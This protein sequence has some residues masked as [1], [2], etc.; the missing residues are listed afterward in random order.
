M[1]RLTNKFILFVMILIMVGAGLGAL[2]IKLTTDI[3][4]VS[5]Y[6]SYLSSARERAGKGVDYYARQDYLKAFAI[7]NGDQA[8]FQEFLAFLDGIQDASYRSYLK[9]Y[10]DMYPTDADAYEKLCDIYYEEKS[11]KQVQTVLLSAAGA[12]AKSEALSDYWEKVA[13]EFSYLSGG[14]ENASVFYGKQSVV[15]RN[16]L[17]GLYYLGSGM[18][19]DAE[20]DHLTYHINGICAVCKA[21]EWYFADGIGNKMGVLDKPVESL[22]ILANGLSAVSADGHFGYVTQELLVPEEL[23]FEAATPFSAGIAAVRVGGRWGLINTQLQYV[24][25]PCYDE[26]K[27]TEFG[28]CVS[29]GV[30]FA[31]EN[32]HYVMLDT[33]GQK[34]V[35][36]IFEEVNTFMPTGEPAAVKLNG[37][38][39]FIE[40]DGSLQEMAQNVYEAKS[41][42]NG[43]APV[44]LDGEKWGYMDQNAKIVI[45]PQFDDCRQFSE[46]GAAPVKNGEIWSFIQ[47]LRY[48]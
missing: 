1:K 43:M 44:T 24:T 16:G 21:G 37:K 48:Q 11:Y 38:W 20:Y 28:T 15:E 45:E 25:E 40:T 3:S 18:V 2:T 42:Q 22:S 27:L 39:M 5:R 47:L 33:Q 7:Y 46:Y 4:M 32:G 17:K 13:Y 31:R 41:F 14:Y 34:I 36:D 23:P 8:L 9:T 12:G 6:N 30:I 19:L 26:I 10:V 29:A 35:D